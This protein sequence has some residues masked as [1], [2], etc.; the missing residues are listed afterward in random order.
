MTDTPAMKISPRLRKSWVERLRDEPAAAAALAIFLIAAATLA[1]AWYFQLVVGLPP[2]PLCLEERIPYH[3]I[4]PLSLL[5]A[6]AAAVRAPEKLVVV[7]FVAIAIAALGN[8]V[9]GTY[10][11]GVEWHWWAGPTDCTG[12]LTDLH[13]GG[14]L[15]TQLQKIHVVRCDEAAWRFL[16]ISLAGYN[17]LI[18]LAIALIAVFGLFSRKSR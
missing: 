12:P 14:S 6:I 5:L 17:A 15:L 7:G 3:V 8:V 1:G 11:A 18:S 10:H 13:A 4:I 16:G 9:L 2:C